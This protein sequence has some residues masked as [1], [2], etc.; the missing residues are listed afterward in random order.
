MYKDMAGEKWRMSYLAV[1]KITIL[2][3]RSSIFK[4][5]LD[6]NQ[7]LNFVNLYFMEGKISLY[8]GFRLS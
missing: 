3:R 7:N 5:I 4:L 2:N 1:S 8:P 6:E